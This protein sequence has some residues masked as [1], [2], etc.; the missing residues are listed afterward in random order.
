M[1]QAHRADI[2]DEQT[3]MLFG[4]Q[5]KIL[6][7]DAIRYRVLDELEWQSFLSR[8]ESVEISG[9]QIRMR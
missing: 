4:V 9:D 3:W 5:E 8:V 1:L 6:G 7:D 2:I